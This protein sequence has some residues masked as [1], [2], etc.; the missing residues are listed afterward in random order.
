MNKL[1]VVSG[2]V[3]LAGGMWLGVHEVGVV[4]DS[5]T[6]VAATKLGQVATSGGNVSESE[7]SLTHK[8]REEVAVAM[9]AGFLVAAGTIGLKRG[10]DENPPASEPIGRPVSESE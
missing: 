1:R 6:Q 9:I 5:S 7:S 4:L 2:G 3:L 10:L 8:I